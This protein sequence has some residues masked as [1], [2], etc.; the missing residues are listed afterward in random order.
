MDV[1]VDK[2]GHV[3]SLIVG[4]GGFSGLVKRMSLFR[5]TPCTSRQKITISGIWS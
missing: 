4:V 3:T 1:L 2:A 5:S